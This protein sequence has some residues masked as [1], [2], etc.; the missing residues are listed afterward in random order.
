MMF[1]LANSAVYLGFR[2]TRVSHVS[3]QH[4][5][6]LIVFSSQRR[7]CLD[8]P[9]QFRFDLSLRASME[10]SVREKDIFLTFKGSSPRSS[11][12]GPQPATEYATVDVG[13]VVENL[14]ILQDT[15]L[16][17]SNDR[18]VDFRATFESS[19]TGGGLVELS[20]HGARPLANQDLAIVKNKV[21]SFV[22]ALPA[23]SDVLARAKTSNRSNVV[24]R[25]TSFEDC[26]YLFC[27]GHP[28]EAGQTV[29]VS[30]PSV[31]NVLRSNRFE[32]RQCRNQHLLV[33]AF[34]V[35]SRNDVR[36]LIG[37]LVE[38]MEK[39]GL[40]KLLEDVSDEYEISLEL[41]TKL[42]SS[43]RARFK[44][45]WLCRHLFRLAP[46]RTADEEHQRESLYFG[47]H[48]PSIGKA[49]S[50][51]LSEIIRSAMVEEF[52]SGILSLLELDCI[53]GVSQ[54]KG[55]CPVVSEFF[56]GLVAAVTMFE[57]DYPAN[58]KKFLVKKYEEI[59]TMEFKEDGD[60]K[61][62]T[63]KVSPLGTNPR[64]G[65]KDVVICSA[66]G[67]KVV[68]VKLSEF[69]DNGAKLAV[70]WYKSFL[71]Q[72]Q[73]KIIHVCGFLLSENDFSYEDLLGYMKPLKDEELSGVEYGSPAAEEF[74]YTADRLALDLYQ[75]HSYQFF[76]GIV[77]P[78]LSEFGWRIQVVEFPSKI[79]Y[80]APQW[81]G[82][83]QKQGK[84][85]KLAKQQRDRRRSDLARAAN[86][87]GLGALPKL[88][89]RL[90]LA[91]KPSPKDGG[92]SSSEKKT[93][94]TKK[95][96]DIAQL[97][98]KETFADDGRS[99]NDRAHEVVELVLDCFD[100]A[101]RP[102]CT[103]VN[104]LELDESQLPR[105]SCSAD[106]FMQFLL[107]LPS[108]LTQSRLELQEINDSLQVVQDLTAFCRE[109]CD[110][111]FPPAI[112]PPIEIYTVKEKHSTPFMVQ[113]LHQASRLN[114]SGEGG[115]HELVEVIWEE[116]KKDLS[117]FVVTVMEQVVA[118]RATEEDARRKHR[119]ITVGY[120]GAVC[121][122]CMGQ[123]GEGRYFF[124]TIESLTTLGTVFEKH[125][126]KCSHVPS[127]IKK[128]IVTNKARHLEQR[129]HLP[130]GSQQ[131]YFLKLWDRLRTMRISGE[132]SNSRGT[133]PIS[134]HPT[135]ASDG[136]AKEES[137]A[138]A[139]AEQ[140][141]KLE[142]DSQLQV[143]DY[144][145]NTA[146]WK[147]TKEIDGSLNQYY[148]CI[149]F[150]GRI[151]NTRGMPKHFSPSWLLGKVGPKQT[152][153]KHKNL[154]G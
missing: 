141:T 29:P 86:Q 143:L 98:L 59:S 68:E 44:I 97:F 88:S 30:F 144:V 69:K 14:P 75:P 53:C 83:H 72:V 127:Q 50:P 39:V 37:F 84:L 54:R 42:I 51:E 9:L 104:A 95:V 147:G 101:G 92:A 131:A 47:C 18:S 150:G 41:K 4:V 93:R 108:L 85:A 10:P 118:C 120:P 133:I 13:G 12:E 154:P 45:H 110:G 90:F 142:F 138:D 7:L 128:A 74:P 81:K 87:L 61:S 28:L 124:T 135:Y 35:L 132:G 94:S 19:R 77:W 80:I 63:F 137:F 60:N 152:K 71:L 73:Y 2:G 103:E 16:A 136:K 102:L 62:W 46:A 82:E 48:L 130:S 126:A 65:E 100:K 33:E 151:Y 38:E 27:V 146:P 123:N 66:K 5:G 105:Y 122:H 58:I 22:T 153:K 134:Q 109:R 34:H 32:E 148:T 25:L 3:S 64:L 112:L 145:R 52:R 17:R 89:K 113:R 115:Y 8:L 121:R 31:H 116:D 139:A 106:I 57:S 125:F 129:K 43:I 40:K 23:D 20:K 99:I 79:K 67:G 76:L 24:V 1:L 15:L 119:K 26:Q 6:S 36:L 107:V 55:W 70:D 11:Q 140:E 21:R 91:S 96:A 114:G 149:D 111:I 56:E 117:D 49:L 78:T